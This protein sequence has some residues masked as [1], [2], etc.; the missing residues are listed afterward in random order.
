MKVLVAG[1]SFSSGWGFNNSLKSNWVDIIKIKTSWEIKNIAVTGNSNLEIF[2]SILN[3]LTQNQYDLIL[4]QFTALNRITV[5][6]SPENPNVIISHGNNELFESIAGVNYRDV[7][8]FLKLFTILNQDWKHYINLIKIINVLQSINEKIVFING[9]L[10]WDRD[11]F[12][13]Q[14]TVPLP[15]HN[16]FVDSLLQTTE[17]DDYSLDKFLKEVILCRN[18]INQSRWVNLYE[19]W[20]QTAIDA[21]S[22]TDPHPGEKSQVKFANQVLKYIN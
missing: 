6:S 11:F 22:P 12:D 8:I 16:H 1:C 20:Q 18:I 14:W 2:L 17:F 13:T 4:C 19:S 3:E 15:K 5:S 9:L 21:I 7:E 10:P